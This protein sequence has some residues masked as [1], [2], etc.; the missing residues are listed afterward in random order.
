MSIQDTI[1]DLESDIEETKDPLMQENFSEVVSYIS[2]LETEL[3][4]Y[5]KFYKSVADLKYAIANLEE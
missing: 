2:H 5:V 3:E 4:K 1:F